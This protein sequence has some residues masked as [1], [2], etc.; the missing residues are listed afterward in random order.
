MA[1]V[2]VQTNDDVIR[3]CDQGLRIRKLTT[4]INELV[5]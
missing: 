2:V 1:E 4:D 3:L 5:R